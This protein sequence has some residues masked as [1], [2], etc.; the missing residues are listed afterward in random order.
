MKNIIYIMLLSCALSIFTTSC[1]HETEMLFDETA[2]QRKTAAVE[3]YQEA[4]KSSD[5][6][7]LFQYFPDE[8]KQYGGYS[9]VVRF[10]ENDSV[11][12]WYE[13]MDDVTNP[14]VSFYD[15]ISYGGPVL[16][17]N[18]YNPFM[19]YFATPSGAEYNAKG[20]DYEFLLMSSES[21]V[22]TLQGTKTG[23]KM[24][25]TKM[26]E[27]AEDY[28]A[29]VKEVS[30]I[31]GGVSFIAKVNGEEVLVAEMNRNFTFEYTDNGNDTSIVVPYIVTDTGI[32]FYEKVEIMGQTVQD[33]ILDKE[34]GQ[35]I[36]TEGE[37][38][39]DIIPSPIQFTGTYWVIDTETEANRSAAFMEV[40]TQVDEANNAALPYPLSK[41]IYLGQPLADYD[42]GL[43]MGLGEYYIQYNLS[44][45]GVKGHE[46]Y[47]NI[48]KIGGGLN[49]EFVP[50]V[51][52]LLNLIVEN[53]PYQ[54]A[55][56]DA[57]NP[58]GYRLT[59]VENPSVWFII[60]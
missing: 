58:T 4:L 36:S 37:V 29:K 47:L 57:E 35:L 40:Y 13:G 18:T 10:N 42:P 17:F 33:F 45:T 50:H 6:G 46:D 23:N 31:I 12:V 7:W 25:L 3:Q 44:F 49:W 11:A 32:S 51:N 53:A 54:V 27:P 21:D 28:I 48:E 26:T 8:E 2:S 19:H 34:N 24:R 60:Q 14:A 59:S 52:P 30:A 9:Y 15:V 20:G 55:L 41:V 38:K 43:V 39:L 22:I 16:T 1:D 56:D 5:E